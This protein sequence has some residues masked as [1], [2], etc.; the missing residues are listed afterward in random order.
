MDRDKTPYSARELFSEYP[1]IY[2]STKEAPNVMRV[3]I[4]MTERIE[5][6]ALRDAVRLTAE[7]YPYFCVELEHRENGDLVFL[8]NSRPVPV[9]PHFY[10]LNHVLSFSPFLLFFL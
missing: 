8:P 6:K 5:E 3:R 1:G 9:I 2:S 4:R 7:R 10:L